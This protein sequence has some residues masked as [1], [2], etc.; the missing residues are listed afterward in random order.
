[1]DNLSDVT[2]LP[3]GFDGRVRLFPLPGLV[4][5]PHAMQPLH[6]FEPRYVEMLREAMASDQLITMATI[7]ED[8]PPLIK[9]PEISPVVCIG[10]VVTH[11]EL[12]DD[13]HN[14]L[15]VGTRRARV[16]REIDAGRSFRIADVDV[17]DDYYEPGENERRTKLKLRLLS[18]F[19]KIIPN[20][21]GAQKNLHDLMAGQMGVG[22]ITDIISYTLPFDSNEKLRLLGMPN[23]DERAEALI[24]LMESGEVQLES[25]SVSE[26]QI[27]LSD[28]K[29]QDEPP[30]FPPPF[31]VN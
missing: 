9:T 15:L 7:L 29:P 11:A 27:D 30:S 2:R 19:G 16:R 23:V 4:M 21:S 5:F 8:A 10:R 22:P 17:I 14:I 20:S 26:Q 28:Q 1:M 3:D 25:V 18:S 31:S 6:L 24:D 13:R 12:D